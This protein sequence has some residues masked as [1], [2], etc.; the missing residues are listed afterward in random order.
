MSVGRTY[1]RDRYTMSHTSVIELAAAARKTAPEERRIVEPGALHTSLGA[2]GRHTW[3]EPGLARRLA[4]VVE[5]HK[6]VGPGPGRT[7]AP[8][9]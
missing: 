9:V 7:W 2:V 5:R 6:S 8:P 4:E 1:C 3:V